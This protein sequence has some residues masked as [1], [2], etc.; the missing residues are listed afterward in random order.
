MPSFKICKTIQWDHLLIDKSL[1][2]E[3]LCFLLRSTPDSWCLVSKR[4]DCNI[5]NAQ[6]KASSPADITVAASIFCFLFLNEQFS[7]NISKETILQRSPDM[8]K[9]HPCT[10]VQ[11]WPECGFRSLLVCWDAFK[12]DPHEEHF[13][14]QFSHHS[15]HIWRWHA[16]V[17]RGHL[18]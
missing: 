14:D 17:W 8:L 18:S 10:E 13:E 12:L 11:L 5:Q 7:L 1:R 15:S 16:D 6:H 9:C 2:Y 4:Q 3:L